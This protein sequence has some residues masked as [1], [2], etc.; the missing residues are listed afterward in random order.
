MTGSPTARAAF[1]VGWQKMPG[2]L[3]LFLWALLPLLAGVL[4]GAALA[5]AF[6]DTAPE[7]AGG[8][9]GGVEL[10][11]I[12]QLEPYPMLRMP[13]DAAHPEPRTV[14]LIQPGKNGAQA[15]LA[16]LDGAT[17]TTRGRLYER[18]GQ[19]LFE[20]GGGDQAVRPAQTIPGFMPAAAKPIG[21]HALAGEV[22]DP[23]CYLGSMQPGEG[24]PHMMCGNRCLFGGIPPMLA[25]HDP[26][27]GLAMVL[28]LAQDGTAAVEPFE[29]WTSLP[30]RVSGDMFAIDDL[31][32]MQ[33][34]TDGLTG[35]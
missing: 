23:K 27:G 28:L 14:L 6:S 35:L 15:R 18:Q 3:A 32:V 22:V 25:A 10:T 1:F 5:L 17:I 2:G 12:V 4:G 13:P 24:K 20:L 7:P 33:V 21:S 16:G 8:S 30:V 26:E 11:G 34:A 31:L 29:P 19:L 9:T